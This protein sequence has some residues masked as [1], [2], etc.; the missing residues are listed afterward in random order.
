[1]GGEADNSIWGF[2]SQKCCFS[3]YRL[4]VP[5]SMP[6]TRSFIIFQT[7]SS[8]PREL[9]FTSTILKRRKLSH[10]E[11]ISS[12][13]GCTGGRGWVQFQAR[14]VWLQSSCSLFD[15]RLP[16][17]ELEEASKK[18]SLSGGHLGNTLG[19]AWI[20]LEAALMI[21][22]LAGPLRWKPWCN[23]TFSPPRQKCQQGLP[24]LYHKP[25]SATH[26]P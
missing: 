9:W 15:T 19:C 13:L 8:Q 25:A 23:L 3:I 26:W 4:S 5:V 17:R 7:E 6:G 1:M 11:V 20:P 12:A 21:I 14:S 16:P 24:R 22:I 2:P 18:R 10:G